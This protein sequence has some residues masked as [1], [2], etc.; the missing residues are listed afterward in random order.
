MTT[1]PFNSDHDLPQGLTE[2]DVLEWVEADARTRS[3]ATPGSSLHRVTRAIASD[4]SLGTML[5]AMRIDRAALGSLE[6]PAPPDW[7]A[8]AVLEEHERQ[9]LLSLS[10]MATISPRAADRG[11]DDDSFSI[12]AMPGWFR[13]AMAVA[14]VLAV[15][16]GAWQLIPLVLPSS[17]SQR[18]P[19]LATNDPVES[20]LTPVTPE[21]IDQ[22]HTAVAEAP[23][24]VTIPAPGVIEPSAA[25]ILT[26]RLDMPVERAL[27]LALAGR[28]IVVVAVVEADAAGDAAE[29]IA[30]QA[31]A[32]TWRLEDAEK[33]LV[34][35]M[36]S[37]DHARLADLDGI[38]EGPISA[39][40][41]GPLGQIEYVMASAPTVFLARASASPEA[42][43]GML[44]GLARLGTEVRLVP[45][46]ERLPG[47][48]EIPAPAIESSL[49][50]WEGDPAAW[51]PW[52]AIPVRFVESR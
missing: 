16:F 30:A 52:A 49:L 21:R 10:D 34:A 51:Q 35:A 7:V 45:L 14:A 40:G 31:V 36:A 6:T 26:A 22:E 13:P 4:T 11:Y 42:L 43:L 18:G 2:S 23:E 5:E 27:E 28:L 1:R 20:D 48:G 39:T 50:W 29:D 8:Q 46:D 37:P 47:M 32:P 41:H 44:D 33:E 19:E 25:E 24:T 38:G 17:G 3:A 9:A 12:S 15:A